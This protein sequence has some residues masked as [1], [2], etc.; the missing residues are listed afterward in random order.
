ML[1][2]RVRYNHTTDGDLLNCQSRRRPSSRLWYKVDDLPKA[3]IRD[4]TH[5]G[6]RSP[7]KINYNYYSYRQKKK[8]LITF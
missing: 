7:V 3:I 6:N 1:Q 8:I 2:V 4:L 5:A